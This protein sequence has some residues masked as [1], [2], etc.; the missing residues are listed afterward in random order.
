MSLKAPEIRRY[1]DWLGHINYR[2]IDDRTTYTAETYPLIDA[3]FTQLQRIT[4]INKDGERELW[5]TAPRG[6]IEDFGDYEEWREWGMADNYDQFR[7]TWLDFFPD[8]IIWYHLQALEDPVNLLRIV[9]INNRHVLEVDPEKQR[10]YDNALDIHPFVE[11]LLESVKVCIRE[12]EAGTY[13]DRIENGVPSCL[14]TGTIIRKDL[15]T[16]F[17][18]WREAFLADIPLAQ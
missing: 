14:R 6:S 9:V 18:E 16:V 3:L 1:I 2:L 11:W 10:Q 4:P 13:I 5:L 12:I 15:W 8:E 7:Q 17:P